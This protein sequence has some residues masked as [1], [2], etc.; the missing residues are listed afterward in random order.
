[1]LLTSQ[2]YDELAAVLYRVG[3]GMEG[4]GR[5][6]FRGAIERLVDDFARVFAADPQFDRKRFCEKCGFPLLNGEE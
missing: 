1:M 3:D 5:T 4:F 6:A 2:E